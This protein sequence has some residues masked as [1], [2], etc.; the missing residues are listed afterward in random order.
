MIFETVTSQELHSPHYTKIMKNHDELRNFILKRIEELVESSDT[1]SMKTMG[2]LSGR[3]GNAISAI[4]RE[5]RIPRLDTLDDICCYFGIT[6]E[7]FFK[8]D[9]SEYTSGAALLELLTSKLEPEYVTVLYKI[10]RSTD[11]ETLQSA[12]DLF[13]QYHDNETKRIKKG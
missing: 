5:Q 7:D 3:S 4:I 9:F 8:R 12:M 11:K 10:L 2:E 13:G 1:K 6:L